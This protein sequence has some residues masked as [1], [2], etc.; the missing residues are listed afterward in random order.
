MNFYT[1]VSKV[2][3]SIAYRGYHD[4]QR[5]QKKIS[6]GP[7]LFRKTDNLYASK[8]RTLEGEPLEPT[9]F[10][11]IS[12]AYAYQKKYKDVPNTKIY[13]MNNFVTQFIQKLYPSEVEFDKSLV[14]VVTI[15]IEVAS[16]DGFPEPDAADH[17]VIS[18]CFK[19]SKTK[20]FIV[21]G[22]G[23]YDSSKSIVGEENVRYVKCD[24]EDDLLM[25]FIEYW[26]GKDT[27]PDVVTGWNVR[28]FDIPYLVNRIR[29]ILDDSYA[30]RL[31]PWKEVRDRSFGLNGKQQQAYDLTGIQQLD[32]W[33]LFQKFGVYSYG[34][35]ESYKL[36]HIANVVLGE[37]KLS[38]EEFG[39]LHSLYKHDYQKFIDYNIKDVQLVERIDDKVDLI[40]LAMTI[41]YK[42]GSNY[43]DAFG[44][45]T[46]W[47]NYIYR[48]L[49]KKHICVPP[50]EVKDGKDDIPGGFVKP[51][52]VGRHSWVVSFDLNSLYPHLIMQYNMSPETIVSETAGGVT[53]QR[54]LHKSIPPFNDSENAVAANGIK[55]RK[56]IR[57]VIPSIIDGLYDERKSIKKEMLNEQQR[58]EEEG[59]SYAAQ[60]LIATLDSQQMAIKIMM[61]SLYGAMGN[62]WFRYYDNRIA[63]AIT[64]SGQ[65]SILW[66]EKAVNEFMSKILSEE[67]DYVIA[68]DTDSLYINFDPLVRMLRAHDK[69]TLEIVQLLDK[70]CA[71]QFE[72]MLERSYNDLAEYMSAYENK[73]FMK[74]EAI[75]DA[76]IWTAKK[77]YILNV[78][79]NEGVQYKEPKLKIMGIEAVK[80]STP[81]SCR[82][83][84]KELFKLMIVSTETE[85]QEAIK[86]FK[87]HFEKLPPHEIAFP[88]GASKVREWKDRDKIYKKGCPIH[89]RGCL[90]YNHHLKDKG[91]E[92][93]YTEVKDG[94]KIKFV[95]L[96][97]PNPIR[98]NI[99]AFPD[100]LPEEFQLHRYV[101]YETQ[102]DKAFLAVVRPVLEAI[103]WTEE[104]SE[105][106]T[107][108][109]FFM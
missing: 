21:W 2:D 48:E 27:S 33:D 87:K 9:E 4:G 3:N 89:V 92:K 83:A 85:T 67:N 41:A 50:K 79:N 72:P 14:N 34:V 30:D 19:S 35:Q 11:N 70:V 75:A 32:Y 82:D 29:K 24:G 74:R 44:T 61:N 51:P 77:R 94:E 55:F 46:L 15:D 40:N 91:L 16:D 39:S 25:K 59:D 99:I 8:W 12:Q 43:T 96:K 101:D 10:K 73:M 37:K 20:D 69:S 109:D 84:L 104:R 22:L 108:D 71:E 86:M 57:G 13:G 76:G 28:L 80:S 106:S 7:T 58:V 95:Y 42:A 53:V 17:A 31:S 107:L 97:K 78:H 90:L 64:L 45:T 54:C 47:D 88:R 66:A 23:D 49:C 18:I 5:I 36:D 105:E 26:D 102:F 63:E 81:A 103:G 38:Y 65:L 62:R 93:K 98:E 68:I 56:D 1:S 60:K 100:Y 52:K 6:F